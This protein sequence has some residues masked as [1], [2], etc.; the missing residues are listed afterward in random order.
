M[1]CQYL[2]PGK[3]GKKQAWRGGRFLGPDHTS[4][5]KQSCAS[6]LVSLTGT[7]AVTRWGPTHVAIV[8]PSWERST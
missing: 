1:E 5:C 6:G 7:G 3:D 2:S 4:T 8:P